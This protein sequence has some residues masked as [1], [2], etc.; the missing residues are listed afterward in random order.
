MSM[1]TLSCP[2]S[3][4]THFSKIVLHT[5]LVMHHILTNSV[6]T[7]SIIKIIFWWFIFG[8]NVLLLLLAKDVPNLV[9]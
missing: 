4:L 9:A 3:E 2:D 5:V 8:R 6:C 1:E 7:D